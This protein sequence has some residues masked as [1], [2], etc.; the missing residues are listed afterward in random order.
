M[1]DPICQIIQEPPKGGIYHGAH[2][3]DRGG[4][5]TE[6]SIKN[7]EEATGTELD[8]I[9]KY[10]KFG[11]GL[12]FPTREAN[13]AS[14]KGGT[15]FIKLE[16]WSGRGEND[17]SFS[18]ENI[19]NGKYNGLLKKFA[20]EVKKF[21][22]PI[23][24]SF[25]H[26]MNVPG[27]PWA[28]D[29]A[30]FQAAFRHVHNILRENGACN[31]TWVWNP[32]VGGDI[33]DY[34]PGDKY[35]DWVAI[36]GYASEDRG[37]SWQSCRELFSG[38]LDSLQD[39]KRPIMIGEF[40]ADA[41]T[42]EDERIKKPKW[43][44]Q[45]INY[46]AEDKRV[47]A[48]L[49][50]NENKLEKGQPK[51]WALNSQPEKDYFR[52][53][54]QKFKL[55]F[56]SNIV[57]GKS[58]AK[59]SSLGWISPDGFERKA[60]PASDLIDTNNGKIN[61]RQEQIRQN[62]EL[63]KNERRGGGGSTEQYRGANFSEYIIWWML[64]R[65]N[66]NSRPDLLQ[67]S[68]NA[69]YANLPSPYW[70]AKV[71]FLIITGDPT[72]GEINYLKKL[73]LAASISTNGRMDDA[74]AHL[75]KAQKFALLKQVYESYKDHKNTAEPPDPLLIGEMQLQL[76][77]LATT[78]NIAK[79]YFASALSAFQ[80]IIEHPNIFFDINIKRMKYRKGAGTTWGGMVNDAK[81]E[82]SFAVGQ[83]HALRAQILLL[84]AGELKEEELKQILPSEI[85]SRLKDIDKQIKELNEQRDRLK[86]SSEKEAQALKKIIEEKINTLES[87][88]QVLNALKP[89]KLTK[90]E[91]TMNL[92]ALAYTRLKTSAKNPN[93]KGIHYQQVKRLAAEA[94]ILLSFILKDYERIFKQKNIELPLIN[95]LLSEISDWENKISPRSTTSY[96]ALTRAAKILIKGITVQS[97]LDWEKTYNNLI[98]DESRRLLWLKQLS[99]YAKLWL[100][101]AAMMEAGEMRYGKPKDEKFVKLQQDKLN[102]AKDILVEII[103]RPGVLTEEGMA[104][105][106]K[107]L[108]ENYA[109]QG[110][111][112]MDQG[113]QEYT[114]K[115]KDARDALNYAIAH[116]MPEVKAEAYL[117]KA[118]IKLVEAG[119]KQTERDKKLAL[120]EGLR[121][122]MQVFKKEDGSPI[123]D[124]IG[125]PLLKGFVLS[126]T[127]QTKGDLL[128]SLKEFD[129]AETALRKAIDDNFPPNYYAY[130]SLGDILNWKGN[131]AAALEFYA[132]VPPDSPA[133]P[134]AQL[135]IAE[136]NM[137]R[138]EVYSDAAIKDLE[139]K[140]IKNIFSYEAPA[141]P[142]IARAIEDLIEAYRTNEDLQEM[143]IYLAKKLLEINVSVELNAPQEGRLMEIFNPI[144]QKTRAA[145]E[146][147]FK[148]E[149][150]LR[151]VEALIWRK[152]FD[153]A[154]DLLEKMEKKPE[155]IA[156]AKKK[157][158]LMILISLLKAEAMMRKKKEAVY[159]EDFLAHES[160]P[161][162]TAIRE[163][164]PDL[165]AR[166]ILDEIEAYSIEKEW[167]KAI[168]AAQNPRIKDEAMEKLFGGRKLGYEKYRFRRLFRQAE[169]LIGKKEFG[170]AAEL[171]ETNI[172][173]QANDL[174]TA[175]KEK[176]L[177]LFAQRA[178]AEAHLMLGNIYSY[179]WKNKN[180]P[181]SR[182]HY[183]QAL[184]LLK[185]DPDPPKEG[186]LILVKIYFGLG[187]IYRYGNEL[188]NYIYSRSN[189][190]EAE[191][192]ANRLPV[193]S[194]DRRSLM[195]Q[196]KV[197]RGRLEEQYGNLTE[198]YFYSLEAV[199]QLD[200]INI[201]DDD[202]K[203]EANNFRNDLSQRRGLNVGSSYQYICGNDH[204]C[205]SQ[206]LMN[207]TFPM[208]YV[209]QYLKWLQFT[210][211][212]QVDFGPGDHIS[213]SYFGFNLIGENL[214]PAT[215]L[216]FG[217]QLRMRGA[218]GGNDEADIRFI[219]RPAHEFLLSIWNK[220]VTL[221]GAI[222]IDQYDFSHSDFNTYYLAL[223]FN[224]S[225]ARSR[226]VRGFRP[227]V[228]VNHYP[229]T[230]EGVLHKRTSLGFLSLRYEAKITNWWS[231]LT[232]LTA[233]VFDSG[234]KWKPGIEF[235][236]GSC[237]NLGRHSS[238]CF[239]YVRQQN[240]E[241]PMDYFRTR[242]NIFTF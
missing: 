66:G 16:P 10:L 84:L 81:T 179:A 171:I 49:Y 65:E 27:Y 231:V 117:W 80:I 7:F 113:K 172:L 23:F 196:I 52:A 1:P 82:T 56:G 177:K 36:D 163:R 197:G 34:Y 116:G 153:D 112:L 17:R 241:Y 62:N 69:Y 211:R 14:Q 206:L 143:P 210:T 222:N 60:V 63:I 20:D 226:F 169:A 232:D 35:V 123:T 124:D 162:A 126:S 219:R 100:A 184:A 135:G 239:E 131:H 145:F 128:S 44:D 207:F 59:P 103:N 178:Q 217:Y 216:T 74:S 154:I 64:E 167:D 45:C 199:K 94:L 187:E 71:A 76:G 41:N 115:F 79:S 13:L 119:K 68:L 203:S 32:N 146:D 150:Y 147:K 96:F 139:E 159:F 42:K 122:L 201:A 200:Q 73:G 188:K 213:R 236:I 129:K 55:L 198:A 166:I 137:R 237:A 89:D 228:V 5:I 175:S 204:R 102:E 30:L 78:K 6:S 151:V 72:I 105:V 127:Y 192:V 176:Y 160:Q 53:S 229:F 165:A 161:L 181:T 180:Y 67:N 25:G 233:L 75:S 218:F 87:E 110:F 104:E 202:L 141:S 138:N 2:V 149:L 242:L 31:I 118:K 90:P 140:T 40:A 3:P 97:V 185:N 186:K 9:L 19:I 95:L 47:K 132:K 191:R 88:K 225:W 107:T 93:I 148:A 38:S 155:L 22:K 83:A 235:T 173:K 223:R 214:I 194:D 212:Q 230:G 51:R 114:L 130:V 99:S 193:K 111:L 121:E 209:S 21:G 182:Q 164:E 227:G 98:K 120:A 238:L 28:M 24:V 106:K 174:E 224:P 142:L 57:I 108:A 11:D 26:E 125:N 205:E 152:R 133:Y 61:A 8:I 70:K 29:P 46:F 43:I 208:H 157:P 158:E 156:G 85:Q 50:F 77:N 134:R 92:L 15:I 215:T 170:K 220:V 101:K 12:K 4:A 33:Q 234:G 37:F 195:T 91:L 18:L 144:D 221:D 190:E 48:Y 183:E 136:A 240:S 58:T 86:T 189:Y 168:A 109:R 39:F 54:I